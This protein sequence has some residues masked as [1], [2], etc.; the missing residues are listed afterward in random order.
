M[1]ELLRI[2]RNP[3]RVALALA[4]RY[5]RLL[6]RMRNVTDRRIRFRPAMLET[7]H[8]YRLRKNG[9]EA[10]LRAWTEHGGTAIYTDD[11]SV[12]E[13]LPPHDAQLLI[14]APLSEHALSSMTR[15]TQTVAVVQTP[16]TWDWHREYASR[17]RPTVEECRAWW[18]RVV[19]SGYRIPL[20]KKD[21]AVRKATCRRWHYRI[22]SPIIL[23]TPPPSKYLG[24]F[25]GALMELEPDAKGVRHLINGEPLC[26][27]SA[28][29]GS[30]LEE[31][32]MRGFIRALTPTLEFEPIQPDW[33]SIETRR[34]IIL[35][36]LEGL[37]RKVDSL[38]EFRM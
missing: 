20:D 28:F 2:D 38:P 32:D 21:R 30:R 34:E 12:A 33:V 25:Y 31:M 19:S 37:I 23:Q 11:Y 18:D 13:K 36:N 35:R 16:R 26:R 15:A 10:Q 22:I 4:N 6:V 17:I 1:T 8:P 29:W 9:S 24:I 14:E 3:E 5:S 27:I 7:I